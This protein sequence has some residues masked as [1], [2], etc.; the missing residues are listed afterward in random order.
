MCRATR[1]GTSDRSTPTRRCLSLIHISEPGFEGAT[2][3]Y[4]NTIDPVSVRARVLPRL[5]D[6]RSRGHVAPD[7]RIG[8]ECAPTPD[9]LRYAG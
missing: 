2:K 3:I 8:D 6:L 7:L 1:S 5:F 9:P 4:L